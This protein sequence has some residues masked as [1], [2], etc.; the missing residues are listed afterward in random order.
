MY[1]AAML[2]ERL[3]FFKKA[4]LTPESLF[5]IFVHG[6]FN[7]YA[8]IKPIKNGFNIDAMFSAKRF[9]VSKLSTVLYSSISAARHTKAHIIF[10]GALNFKNNHL[11]LS[12][13]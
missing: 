3:R 10:F 1:T 4:Y 9:T 13:P 12:E 11:S 7:I 2:I 6:I 5:S 8:I